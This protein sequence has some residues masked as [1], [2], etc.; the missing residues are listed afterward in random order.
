MLRMIL[1]FSLTGVGILYT[2][3]SPFAGILFNIATYLLNPQII[4]Q[5]APALRYQFLAALSLFVSYIIH[6]P[7]GLPRV[8][9]E[10][11]ALRFLWLFLVIAALGCPFAQMNPD[12]AWEWVYDFSKTV[13]ISSMFVLIIRTEK[14]VVT[15]LL[16]CLVG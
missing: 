1:Y 6:Q 15:V 7:R 5:E 8:G 13:L 9:N 14:Q 12:V 4:T 2:L 16:A 11:A 10:G 3:A